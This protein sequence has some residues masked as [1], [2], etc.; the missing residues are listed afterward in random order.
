MQFSKMYKA[1]YRFYIH[2]RKT[3][4]LKQNDIFQDIKTS[5]KSKNP[6][7]VSNIFKLLILI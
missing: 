2:T 1:I 6:G 5:K 4:G 3:L 7:I